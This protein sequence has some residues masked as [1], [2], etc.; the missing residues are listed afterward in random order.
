MITYG[1]LWAP[2]FVA[3]V[4]T[5]TML[6]FDVELKWKVACIVVVV[7]CMVMRLVPPIE[8]RVHFIWPMLLESLVAISLSIWL[9]L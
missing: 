1:L 7:A 5:I 6:R 4:L 3:I 2:L 8:A 9:K